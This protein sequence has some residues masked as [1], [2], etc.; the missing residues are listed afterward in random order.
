MKRILQDINNQTF[1]TVY[2]LYGQ[3]TYLQ[4]QYRDNLLKALVDEGDTMNV[5]RV[6]GK[7]YSIPAPYKIRYTLIF[8]KFAK[9]GDKESL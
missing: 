9:S 7:E 8:E 1:R 3:E 4:K 6:Q 2:V 5:W